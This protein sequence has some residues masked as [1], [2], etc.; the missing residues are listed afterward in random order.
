VRLADTPTRD[1]APA[2]R[3]E[4]APAPRPQPTVREGVT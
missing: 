4:Q 1:T 3:P 2:A